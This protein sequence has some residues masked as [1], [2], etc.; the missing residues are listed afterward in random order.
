MSYPK[1][2][3]CKRQYFEVAFNIFYLPL[4]SFDAYRR[5]ERVV[6]GVNSMIEQYDKGRT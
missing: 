2:N 6:M 3:I 4:K 5:K 1:Y